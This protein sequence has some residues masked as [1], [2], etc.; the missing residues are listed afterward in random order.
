[1][2]SKRAKCLMASCRAIGR[3]AMTFLGRVKVTG[4]DWSDG[5]NAVSK[6]AEVVRRR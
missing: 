6:P 2:T 5:S 1:M 3:P 4:D